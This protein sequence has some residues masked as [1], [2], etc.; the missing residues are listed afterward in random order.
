MKYE[1]W[2]VPMELQRSGESHK[3]AHPLAKAPTVL[4][5]QRE[6]SLAVGS[7]WPV[8]TLVVVLAH[9]GR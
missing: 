4:D 7:F 2:D 9:V 8:L 5:L 1:E 6:G 3:L